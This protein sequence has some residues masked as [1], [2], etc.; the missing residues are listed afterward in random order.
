MTTSRRVATLATVIVLF[1]SVVSP[2]Q[3]HTTTVGQYMLSRILSRTRIITII[4]DQKRK[5]SFLTPWQKDPKQSQGPKLPLT[6]HNYYSRTIIPNHKSFP[7]ENKQKTKFISLISK[8]S[9][10]HTITTSV[11]E[12]DIPLDL[13]HSLK[14]CK[15]DI[16][17][18]P[19]GTISTASISRLIR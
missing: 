1:R 9:R 18:Y 13:W 8:Y 7:N 4:I 10:T 12:R 3:I 17:R 6:H 15:K 16:W 19:R 2:F 5:F 14:G 11:F